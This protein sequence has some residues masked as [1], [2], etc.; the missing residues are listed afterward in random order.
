V[1]GFSPESLF[2]FIPEPRSELS[3]NPFAFIR[4]RVRLGPESAG[5][6]KTLPQSSDIP[7]RNKLLTA[8]TGRNVK[9]ERHTSG[10]RLRILA[11]V[12][13]TMPLSHLHLKQDESEHNRLLGEMMRVRTKIMRKEG[14]LQDSALNSSGLH[15][16]PGD[17]Q[18]WHLLRLRPDGTL[19]G[20]ARILVH[21]PGVKFNDLRIA[22][23]KSPDLKWATLLRDAV[24]F[25]LEQARHFDR[26]LIEPGG[27]TLDEDQQGSG[28]GVAIAVAAFA[29]A[30]I[31][32]DCVGFLTAT[33]K[34]CSSKILRR[35]GGSS[36]RTAEGHSVPGYF[37][38]RWSTSIDLLRFDTTSLAPCFARI[39]EAAHSMLLDTPVIFRHE[40]KT[41]K[42]Q[43][44]AKFVLPNMGKFFAP[45]F[46]ACGTTPAALQSC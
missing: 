3:R 15:S 4:N 41:E 40:P 29:W 20:C 1:F 17:A 18:S 10:S 16:M 5:R 27:W 43:S 28:G 38:S 45:S 30:R 19:S 13:C 11:P 32:G 8:H 21:K 39:L 46:P 31:L 42:T 26:L 22:S 24:E 2:A 37:D 12:T 7:N 9:M 23:C 6:L 33:A 35:L 14:A 25:E 36:L 44:R 34:T